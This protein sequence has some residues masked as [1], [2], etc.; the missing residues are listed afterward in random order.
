M[1]DSRKRRKG[2]A[3]YSHTFLEMFVS[4]RLLVWIYLSWRRISLHQTI[5]RWDDSSTQGWTRDVNTSCGWIF[6]FIVEK[7]LDTYHIRYERTFGKKTCQIQLFFF[8][9]KFAL[10]P[11]CFSFRVGM[12]KFQSC[13]KTKT[14]KLRRRA[15]VVFFRA[16]V[17]LKSSRFRFREGR[18]VWKIG[19]KLKHH[20][21]LFCPL[22]T[23]WSYTK[24]RKGGCKF[25]VPFVDSKRRLHD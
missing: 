18:T 20:Q 25:V 17:E 8:G 14:S 24:V 19:R 21:I 15:W 4:M 23:T 12:F 16:W 3:V 6:V 2:L 1:H 5:E 11:A 22:F 7:R 13:S 10:A 9:R